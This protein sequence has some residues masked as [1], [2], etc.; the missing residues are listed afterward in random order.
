M[1]WKWGYAAPCC[2]PSVWVFWEVRQHLGR[3]G[4][5]WLLPWQRSK[6]IMAL[7]Q[8]NERQGFSR[9]DKG[10]VFSSCA[11]FSWMCPFKCPV[12]PGFLGFGDR[13]A[14]PN[15]P[16]MESSSSVVHPGASRPF[17]HWERR[18]AVVMEL[19]AEQWHLGMR[20][21]LGLGGGGSDWAVCLSL[22]SG[23]RLARICSGTLASHHLRTEMCLFGA[24]W[25]SLLGA[26]YPGRAGHLQTEPLGN[27]GGF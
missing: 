3:P 17:S 5:L 10:I 24:G 8:L 13:W 26:E 21:G 11:G 9:S 25:S 18:L 7:E 6:E 12:S 1:S 16:Q 20:V 4:L 2:D 19:G 14:E 22:S 15:E 23:L 27:A